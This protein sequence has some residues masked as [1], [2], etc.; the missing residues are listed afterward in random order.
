MYVASFWRK[1]DA[2][3]IPSLLEAAASYIAI[4]VT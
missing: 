1:S 3:K 2:Q 4:Y